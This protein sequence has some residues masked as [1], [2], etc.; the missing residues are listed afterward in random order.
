MGVLASVGIV[1]SLMQ[2]LVIPLIPQLPNLLEASPS[3]ASWVITA[4]LL[5]GA[6]A[7]P[8]AGRLGDIY[9]KRLLLILSLA[10]LVAGS[11]ICATSVTVWPMVAGRALQGMAMGAI[12]LGISILHDELPRERIGSAIAAMSATMGVGGAIGLPLASVIAQYSN[13]HTL[14]WVAAGLGL[15]CLLLVMTMLPES[16]VRTPS[17]FDVPGALGLAIGLVALLLP[18]SKGATWGCSSPLTLGLLGGSVLLLVLWGF[19]ELRGASPLVD[20]RVTVQPPVLFTNFASVAVGFSMYGMSLVFPQ[21]LMAPASTGYGLGL[22]MV[23][24][25]LALTPGGLVMMALSPVSARLSARRGPR[26][27]LLLGSAVI[28]A[29]YVLVLLLNAQVWQL[30]LASMAIAAGI[31]LAYAEMPALIMGSVRQHESAAANGLN[32]LMRAVGTSGSA[33][34]LGVVLASMGTGVAG[35]PMMAGFRVAFAIARGAALLAIVLTLFIPR[36]GRLERVAPAPVQAPVPGPVQASLARAH[37]AFA[38]LGLAARAPVEFARRDFRER[39]AG[40]AKPALLV[41]AL[42][43]VVGVRGPQR[44]R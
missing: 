22:D 44:A 40:A 5:S 11:L 27:T 16:S 9:G 17:R 25:G 1:V 13:W 37:P 8:I 42:V 19:H 34:V 38:C 36:H 32:A 28:G 6:A 35:V 41:L 30:V 33:A 18:V 39:N 3:D 26:T 15:A 12:P 14:F 23:Q 21:L 4:T 20:L 24:A 2:T 29:G 10:L 31:G 7:T 43:G